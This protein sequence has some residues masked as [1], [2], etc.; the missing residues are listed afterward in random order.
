[1]TKHQIALEYAH[2]VTRSKMILDLLVAGN[3]VS[4]AKID[5]AEQVVD[6]FISKHKAPDK[7]PKQ[8]HSKPMIAG[9]ILDP[10]RASG[11]PKRKK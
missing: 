2:H 8:A 9:E 5:Q 10:S 1:M 3:H 6:Q 11:Y 7:T 4:Q